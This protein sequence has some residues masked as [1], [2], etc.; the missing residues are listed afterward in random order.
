[1]VIVFNEWTNNN[2]DF[3]IRAYQK[4]FIYFIGIIHNHGI[5]IIDF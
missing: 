2:N 4:L 5:V 3:F 1:M